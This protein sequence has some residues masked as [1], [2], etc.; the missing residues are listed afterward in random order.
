MVCAQP[1]PKQAEMGILIAKKR[2]RASDLGDKKL[3]WRELV[4]EEEEEGS[5]VKSA[6]P[7]YMESRSRRV[8]L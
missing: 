4:E 6:L 7:C 5:P 8:F 3:A 1:C 2:I